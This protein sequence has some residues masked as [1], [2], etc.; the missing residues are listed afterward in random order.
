ML[1]EEI[2]R[3]L[4]NHRIH[5]ALDHLA[6]SGQ[7]GKAPCLVHAKR[8]PGFFGNGLEIVRHR[9]KL[10]AAVLLE[11]GRDPSSPAAGSDQPDLDS[12]S[13]GGKLTA[14]CEWV[15]NGGSNRPPR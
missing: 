5:P 4:E 6:E 9:V 8:R 10:V 12:G 2:W 13:G 11:Q 15:K 7:A 3:R 1:G 14:D